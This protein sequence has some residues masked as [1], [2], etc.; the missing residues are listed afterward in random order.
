MRR[1]PAGSSGSSKWLHHLMVLGLATTVGVIVYVV[2][3][4]RQVALPGTDSFRTTPNSDAPGGAAHPHVLFI[5]NARVW[6]GDDGEEGH[7]HL[8]VADSVLV[9]DDTIRAVGVEAS[10]DMQRQLREHMTTDAQVPRPRLWA[11]W[12]ST[13]GGMRVHVSRCS[14]A[15]DGCWWCRDSST[16]TCIT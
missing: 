1:Q 14:M 10:P 9:V 4:P 7:D 3:G 13:D 5:R 16:A 2:A 11:G 6:S 12:V 15:R 8:P